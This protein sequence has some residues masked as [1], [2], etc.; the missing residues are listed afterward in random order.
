MTRLRRTI[1]RIIDLRRACTADRGLG[2]SPTTHR[3]LAK[4]SPY[5]L[6]QLTDVVTCDTHD[7][8]GRLLGRPTPTVSHEIRSAAL[9]DAT[10]PAQ[11][12][13]ETALL[14]AIGN[15][16][17]YQRLESPLPHNEACKRVRPDDSEIVL[18]L[19][20]PALAAVLAEL[21]PHEHDGQL[22]GL[23][24][25]RLRQSRR[26]VELYLA[27]TTPEASVFIS[28][29]TQHQ[30]AAA[31]AFSS[32]ATGSPTAPSGP[33]QPLS[34]LEMLTAASGR[35][36]GPTALGSAV[37]RRLGVF[38]NAERVAIAT[39]GSCLRIDWTGGDT[40]ASIATLL[41]HPVVGV[42][43][44]T[45]TTTMTPDGTILLTCA[46]LHGSIALRQSIPTARL[47]SGPAIVDAWQTFEKMTAA[48][49]T[50]PPS[51]AKLA[52]L[53]R[54]EGESASSPQ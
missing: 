24:G 40:P 39:I 4:L 31:L 27:D 33:A 5:Q 30:L 20:P 25:L 54:D 43:N 37:F 41:T 19:T 26:Q 48:P 22:F 21:L 51:R 23:A 46:D 15:L 6:E 52:A 44:D 34:D 45:F 28:N 42:P 38:R 8:G 32:I 11:Q 36:P 9:P 13:L 2:V 50:A 3:L 53:T 17:R 47:H 14:H 7:F 12:E 29:I 10:T 18:N 16:G 49:P 35:A 1:T